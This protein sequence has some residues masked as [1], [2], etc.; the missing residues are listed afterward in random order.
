MTHAG[1][2]AAGTL[3]GSSRI[4]LQYHG[5]TVPSFAQS[6]SQCAFPHG[7][8]TPADFL[9]IVARPETPLHVGCEL[10]LPEVR[11]S[12]WTG[13]IRTS[14]MTVP[15]AAMHE[16]DRPEAVEDQVRRSGKLPVM[17]LV[18]EAARMQLA[19]KCQFR[20]R[21]LGT[22][23]RHHARP[24]RC[25]DYIGHHSAC[26]KCQGRD[27]PCISRKVIDAVKECRPIIRLREQVRCRH[28]EMRRTGSLD[29]SGVKAEGT[30]VKEKSIARAF[31]FP[32]A[33]VGKPLAA[34]APTPDQP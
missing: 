10:R 11:P 29:R 33:P 25:I 8:H 21:V 28:S 20:F 2:G 23:P 12:G 19:A 17:Q 32:M 18:S 1:A 24:G 6:V 15:E 4:H 7:R 13:R 5:A 30:A 16:T 34:S 3:P 22:G 14:G 26:S 31:R 27:C 9:Q